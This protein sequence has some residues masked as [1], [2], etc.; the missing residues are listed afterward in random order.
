MDTGSFATVDLSM[1]TR[2]ILDR[3]TLSARITNVL[4]AAYALPGGTQHFLDEIRQYGR[5]AQ[6]SVKARW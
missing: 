5:R 4:D 2:P 1:V 3:V 6:F